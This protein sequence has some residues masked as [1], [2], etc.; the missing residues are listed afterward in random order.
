MDLNERIEQILLAPDSSEDQVRRLCLAAKEHGFAAVAVPPAWARQAGLSL[1]S[2]PVRLDVPIGYPL[3]THTSSVKG[4]EA[5]L[6]IEEGA[7]EVT[8]VPNL[9]DYRSGRHEHFQQDLNYAIRQARQANPNVR[10]KVL[11]Y[12]DLLDE[13][14][15]KQV[16]SLVQRSE[17]AAV[18]LSAYQEP[19]P[20]AP[21]LERIRGW[22]RSEIQIETMAK[23]NSLEEATA[24]LSLGSDRLVTPDGVQLA[25]AAQE[26]GLA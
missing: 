16:L 12:L 23:L 6:A 15:L 26:Q 9:A 7:A 18:V 19:T 22:V 11:V 24:L 10:S 25:Q 4:L 3:G 20:F 8:I 1:A 17:I 5:R 14:G 13:A 21:I 2:S